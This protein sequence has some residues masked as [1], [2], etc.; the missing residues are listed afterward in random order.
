MI[1]MHGFKDTKKCRIKEGWVDAGKEG[2]CYGYINLSQCWAVVVMAD[3][4]EPSLHKIVGLE[5]EIT[6]VKWKGMTS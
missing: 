5:E 1:V 6:S 3:E 2:V 4:S